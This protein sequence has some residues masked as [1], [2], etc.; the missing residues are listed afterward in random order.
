MLFG[1]RKSHELF[2]S[3]EIGIDL[4]GMGQLQDISS[5]DM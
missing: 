5:R 1:V 3:I 4:F 2:L